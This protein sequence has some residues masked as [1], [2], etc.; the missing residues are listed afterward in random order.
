MNNIVLVATVVAKKGKAE[1]VKAELNKLIAPTK[2]E[3]G[4]VAYKIHQD[5]QNDH[6]FVAIEQ[7]ADQNA[8]KNHMATDHFQNY[9]VVTTQNDAIESFEYI[10]LTEI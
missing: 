8:I 10:T 5:L 6:K 3:A 4:N 2:A 1:F 7:W 9:Q